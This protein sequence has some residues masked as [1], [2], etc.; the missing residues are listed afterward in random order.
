MRRNRK[1]KKDSIFRTWSMS[2][3]GLMVT[4]FV[5][6][7]VYWTMDSNC[8]SI[9]RKI[10]ELEKQYEKYEKEY[11]REEAR[12]S[13]MVTRDRLDEKLSRFGIQMGYAR[14]DQ[15]VKMT[16][17]GTPVPKQLSVA[18]LRA[19]N[20]SNASVAMLSASMVPKTP[21][22]PSLSSTASSSLKT[23]QKVRR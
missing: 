14:P 10:G 19:R 7:M 6:L 9:H 22:R 18:R 21:A 15:V 11:D 12:W 1:I 23:R 13:S 8:T 2:F 16:S 17:D 3:A 5:M 20:Q 4:L